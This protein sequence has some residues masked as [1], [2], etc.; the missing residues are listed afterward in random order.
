[1]LA[2]SPP[3]PLIIDYMDKY[4]RVT[5]EDHHDEG[6]QVALRHRDRVR[7]IRLSWPI[8][9][10]QKFIIAINDE[11]PMLEY[12][13]IGP[14]G[15]YGTSP[16]LALTTL[17][18][19]HLRHLILHGF[20]FPTTTAGLV[21]LSLT[22]IYPSAYFPP[23]HLLRRLSIMPQLETLMI[24]FHFPIPNRDIERQLLHAPITTNAILP[25]LR[26]FRFKGTSAYLE[27]LL[28]RI[29]APLLERLN[30]TFFN[31]LTL[32]IPHLLQFIQA[33]EHL[34]FNNAMIGFFDQ[35]VDVS[36]S[37]HEGAKV[38]AFN[39]RVICPHLDWQV[40][41]AVQISHALRAEF[42]GV[43]DLTLEYWGYFSSSQQHHEADQSQWLELLMLYS[44]V[45]T[46]RLEDEL[47]WELSRSLQ[48]ADGESSMELLPRLERLSYSGSRLAG[49]AFSNFLHV[50]YNAGHPITL[51]HREINPSVYA[52]NQHIGMP[53]QA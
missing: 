22:N 18:A 45:K 28:P 44:N 24:G 26:S 5:A 31:Q 13:Y 34:E 43:E 8:P 30:V 25:N 53:A 7:R 35:G 14:L 21:T 48:S 9:N 19:P 2:H 42:S 4:H 37:P 49:Q 38:F 46:L 50:R 17:Q 16:T 10:L 23:N 33:T 12:L 20:A 32:S 52:R 51:I 41:L 6:I 3:F 29:T 36:V 39:M 15:T 40:A 27:A 1:M 47:V 11:F